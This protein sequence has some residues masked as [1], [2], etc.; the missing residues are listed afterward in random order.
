MCEYDYIT[1]MSHGTTSS[2]RIVVI[3]V[4]KEE[5]LGM[6]NIWRT[7]SILK[8]VKNYESHISGILRRP[9]QKKH[10]RNNTREHHTQIFKNYSKRK[11]KYSKRENLKSSQMMG[12]GRRYVWRN[13][14]FIRSN[15]NQKYRG[16]KSLTKLKNK[17]KTIIQYN[18]ISFKKKK[19][20][21]MDNFSCTEAKNFTT[22]QTCTKRNIKR[23]SSGKKQSYQT[24]PWIYTKEMGARKASYVGSILLLGGRL[25]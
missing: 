24:K 17:N 8:N 14:F 22:K 7:L 4:P 11:K 9:K 25:I 19:K 6:K 12:R 18:Q 20:R 10:K 23:S 1:S 5:H 16:A 13:R 21:N 2:S 3:R 15:A